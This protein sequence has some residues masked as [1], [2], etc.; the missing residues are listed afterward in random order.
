MYIFFVAAMDMYLLTLNLVVHHLKCMYLDA[1]MYMLS[2]FTT[3]NSRSKC[4][5]PAVVK[6]GGGGGGWGGGRNV[7]A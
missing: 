1:L 7:L 6:G 5:T 2:E 3:F 4:I